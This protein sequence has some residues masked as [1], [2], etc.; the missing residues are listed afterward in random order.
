[1]KLCISYASCTFMQFSIETT[2]VQHVPMLDTDW[3]WCGVRA[4]TA[5]AD[6]RLICLCMHVM[7]NPL[8][9][10]TNDSI[11]WYTCRF[12]SRATL[13]GDIT[14]SSI[15]NEQSWVH[16]SLD[17]M[18]RSLQNFWTS[19]MK[20]CLIRASWR[21]PEKSSLSYSSCPVCPKGGRLS[22]FNRNVHVLC[23]GTATA[24]WFESL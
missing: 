24:C 9:L 13:P 20:L 23:G 7:F 4:N 15:L 14:Q 12:L 1:M 11:Q 19:S 8:L 22:Q 5:L 16:G 2:R 3:T 17:L 21:P 10:I 6:C 18:H